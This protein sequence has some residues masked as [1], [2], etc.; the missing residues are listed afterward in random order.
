MTYSS[1]ISTIPNLNSV[2]DWN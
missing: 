1:K 2:Q